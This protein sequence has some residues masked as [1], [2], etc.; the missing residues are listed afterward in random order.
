MLKN[1]LL[2]DL[3]LLCEE[4]VKSLAESKRERMKG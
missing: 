3:Y 2:I 4:G 1:L